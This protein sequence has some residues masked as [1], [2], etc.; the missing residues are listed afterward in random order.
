MKDFK[1]KYRTDHLRDE[2]INS[3]I[4]GNSTSEESLS[5]KQR[6][7]SQVLYQLNFKSIY[8]VKFIFPLY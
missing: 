3:I 7:Q 6:S 8:I 2:E 1:G 4:K 5:S